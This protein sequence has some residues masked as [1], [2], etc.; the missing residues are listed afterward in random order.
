MN[1]I[2]LTLQKRYIYTPTQATHKNGILQSIEK[3]ERPIRII[4]ESFWN[5]LTSPVDKS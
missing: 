3:V 1:M 5:V 4:I 2:T